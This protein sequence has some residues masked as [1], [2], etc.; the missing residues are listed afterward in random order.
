[1]TTNNAPAGTKRLALFIALAAAN[2]LALVAGIILIPPNFQQPGGG[3]SSAP[4]STSA[5]EEGAS[6]ARDDGALGLGEAGESDGYSIV[7]DSA[8]PYSNYELTFEEELPEGMMHIR[9]DFT[10]TNLNAEVGTRDSF[11]GLR[12]VYEDAPSRDDRDAI[13]SDDSNVF[14]TRPEGM[15]YF[16]EPVEVGESYSS[17]SLFQCP[18]GAT[19]VTMRYYPEPRSSY[20]DPI[21]PELLFRFE[22]GEP[23]VIEPPELPEGA[24]SVED[25]SGVYEY[26]DEYGNTHYIQPREILDDFMIRHDSSENEYEYDPITGIAT[27]R[28]DEDPRGHVTEYTVTFKEDGGNMLVT[29]ETLVTYPDGTPPKRERYEGY[30]TD[31]PGT[32]ASEETGLSIA[33]IAGT[34]E[35]LDHRDSTTRQMEVTDDDGH[36]MIATVGSYHYRYDPATGVAYYREKQSNGVEWENIITFTRSPGGMAVSFMNKTT[37]PT[38]RIDELLFEGYRVDPPGTGAPPDTSAAQAPEE[39]GDETD[40]AQP[41]SGADLSAAGAPELMDFLWY[42]ED[43]QENDSPPGAEYLKDYGRIAGSWKGMLFDNSE[44]VYDASYV[45]LFTLDISGG[46]GDVTLTPEW[47]K[48]YY[49][50]DEDDPHNNEPTDTGPFEGEWDVVNDYA[51]INAEDMGGD[52]TLSIGLFYE[53]EQKQYALGV[54]TWWD[55]WENYIVLMRP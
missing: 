32:G 16:A 2:V 27:S 24:L 50:F 13:N 4:E 37:Y 43:V 19:E 40:D 12:I 35:Y 17:W 33:E 45:C 14:G 44:N 23:I 15:Y 52:N 38:G 20:D 7:I 42:V 55:G 9:V 51:F 31:P 47:H 26:Q 30:R 46:E 5:R 1:M 22:L 34:Y 25:I 54:L 10:M 28:S 48:A 36:L 53:Y 18:V 11:S 8:A 29:Y 41:V 49:S 39:D 6:S 3:P 21:Q